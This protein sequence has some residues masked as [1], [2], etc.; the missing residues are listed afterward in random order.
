MQN[1]N[2]TI[3]NKQARTEK[4]KTFIKKILA[5]KRANRSN[6]DPNA[7]IPREKHTV[8]RQNISPNSLKVLNQLSR[9]GY[10]AY[11]VG[12]GV[13]DTLVGLKPKDFDITT[14]AKPNQIKNVFKNCRLIGRRFRLAHVFFGREIIE[15]ATFRAGSESEKQNKN[16]HHTSASGI[17]KRDN[18]F[19]S[20]EEDAWRRDITINAL[21]Y[22]IKD[23]SLVD[24]TGGLKDIK[25]KT[26]RI[27]GEPKVR[28]TEDPVRMLRVVRLAAKLQFNIEPK[29]AEPICKMAP[30]LREI[31]NA[32]LFDEAVKLFH[33]GAAD[34]SFLLLEQYQLLQEL[35]PTAS[36]AIENNP[37]A[38]EFILKACK[39]TNARINSNKTVTPAFLFAVML[40]QVFQDTINQIINHE[41]IPPAQAK[42]AAASRVLSE[43]N[44]MTAIPKR[45]TMAIRE[46]WQLQSRLSREINKRSL[47]NLG[48]PRFRAAYDF[49]L[50]RAEIEPE[51]KHNA[52][53]WTDY[54]AADPVEQA[55][56]IRTISKEPTKKKT[57]KNKNRNKH[58]RKDNTEN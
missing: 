28:Y 45:F 32:R 47:N 39:N 51:L 1:Q 41:D 52:Q 26:I 44:A 14:N 30:H 23:F 37:N 12:G 53:W 15:V 55:A 34:Q 2:R 24:L 46:I 43:Q 54:Q 58:K 57:S 50:L 35:F 19:G 40:W 10:D 20:L 31:S 36:K 9:A 29:T 3:Q 56:M 5:K 48:H 22:N 16:D 7:I 25:S 17:V 18:V 8:S 33:N 4:I 6:I 42:L 13:R 49:L 21:Y 11:L 38:K 27:I